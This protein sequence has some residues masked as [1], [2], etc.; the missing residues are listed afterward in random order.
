MARP[1]PSS[2]AL[3]VSSVLAR[4]GGA[5]EPAAGLRRPASTP[6]VSTKGTLAE[7]G[8]VRGPEGVGNPQARRR[9]D[10]NLAGNYI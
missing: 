3:V 8:W 5:P 10:R 9:Y 6:R 4:R 2:S 1:I 7:G